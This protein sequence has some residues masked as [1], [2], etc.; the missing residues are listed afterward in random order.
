[1][2]VKK[3]IEQIAK[4]QLHGNWN[5]REAS[6]RLAEQ[7]EE[8]G[9]EI[10]LISFDDESE[11]YQQICGEREYFPLTWWIILKTSC[12]CSK[13]IEVTDKTTADFYGNQTAYCRWCGRESWHEGAY[14]Y[15]ALTSA[16]DIEAAVEEG[17]ELSDENK[18]I[19][20]ELYP[21]ID[22]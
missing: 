21:D 7:I 12:K 6:V 11:P 9:F 15:E 17:F 1:M 3:T 19:I 4:T 18:R 8:A 20:I 10:H 2:L 16:T 14:E 13:F 22:L 5:D